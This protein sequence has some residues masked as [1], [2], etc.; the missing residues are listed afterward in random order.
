MSFM[1]KILKTD[2][3]EIAEYVY[4]LGTTYEKAHTQ[5]M[6][7]FETHLTTYF[8]TVGAIW[9]KSWGRNLPYTQKMA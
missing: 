9:G 8:W 3:N 1:L 5:A 2:K 7:H 6:S 4:F